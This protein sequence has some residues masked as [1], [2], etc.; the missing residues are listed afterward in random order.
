MP[1]IDLSKCVKLMAEYHC[2]GLCD[3]NGRS[4]SLWQLPISYELT[5]DIS[6]WA[7]YLD[8]YSAGSTFHYTF[9]Y[10]D[11]EQFRK[12]G[13]K[14]ANRLQSELPDWSVVYFNDV[15]MEHEYVVEQISNVKAWPV[16]VEQESY[17]VTDNNLIFD[18]LES[19]DIAYRYRW[20][21]CSFWFKTDQDAALFTLRWA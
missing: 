12:I 11:I 2:T 15:T 21:S 4:V 7:E 17:T 8:R 3:A 9:D 6:N 19:T 14:L 13:S 1:R 10:F 5:T 16:H 20:H 18:W